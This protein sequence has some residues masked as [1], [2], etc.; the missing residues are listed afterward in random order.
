MR[1]NI[2]YFLVS[3]L[4]WLTLRAQL[5][6]RFHREEKI[7]QCSQYSKTFAC[8]SHLQRHK[9]ILLERNPMNIINVVKPL[10]TTIFFDV[11]KEVMLEKTQ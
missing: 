5:Y 11:M 10:H 8:A 3:D 7:Y 1:G 4:I 6:E 9:K 2:Q